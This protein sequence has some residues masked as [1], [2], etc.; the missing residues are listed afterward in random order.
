MVASLITDLIS[1]TGREKMACHCSPEN[2]QKKEK[3]GCP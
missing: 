3:D 2:M 1:T